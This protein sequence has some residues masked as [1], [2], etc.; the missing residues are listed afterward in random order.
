MNASHRQL[1]FP[2][3]NVDEMVQC[4]KVLLGMERDWIPNRPLHSIYLRPTSI[5]MDNRLG[6][7]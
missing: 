7:S 1:G 4:T 3:F 5:C 6:L 2:Q